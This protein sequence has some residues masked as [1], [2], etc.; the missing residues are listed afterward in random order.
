MFS[1]EKVRWA[2]NGF[3]AFKATGE[4][5]IFP[6]LLQKGLEHIVET[7]VSL[8]RASFTWNYI[9]TLWRKVNVIF[10]PKADRR[11][12]LAK[13]YRPVSLTSFLLKTMEK[14]VD[15]HIRDKIASTYPIHQAQYAY[16]KGKSTELALHHLVQGLEN[17]LR[18]KEFSLGAFLDIQGAFDNTGYDAI[19]RALNHKEVDT[20]ITRWISSMLKGRI[21]TSKIGDISKTIS[22]TRGCPQGGVLSPLLWSLVMDELITLLYDNRYRAIGYADDLAIH[23]TGIDEGTVRDDMKT[24]L[25]IVMDWCARVGLNANP[26]KTTLVPF[27]NRRFKIKLPLLVKNVN[28]P[29]KE[30]VKYLGVI[31]D[32]HLNWGPHIDHICAKAKKALFTSSSYCGKNWG[33]KPELMH[34]MYCT[35]VRPIISYAAWIWWKKTDQITFQNELKKVQRLACLKI[36][37]C[38]R[39]TPTEGI[40]AIIGLDPLHIHVK[41]VAA[42]SAARHMI[43]SGDLDLSGHSD[44]I[45][46]IPKWERL[47]RCTD[48]ITPRRDLKKTFSTTI[49][50]AEG[51]SIDKLQLGEHTQVWYTDGSKMESG[52]G[53]G[54]SGP[55]TA[56]SVSLGH[57]TTIFQAEMEA[58]RLCTDHLLLKRPKGQNFAILSDSQASIKA[59]NSTV[60]S[61]GLV[62]ECL[63]S[64][65]NLTKHNKLRLCWV[66]GHK[67][68]EGNEVADELARQ[69]AN[70]RFIGP[71]PHCGLNWS[72]V[73]GAIGE[74]KASARMAH[75]KHT[76]AIR[77]SKLL[78]QPFSRKDAILLGRND[79]RRIVGYLTGH[80]TLRYNLHKMQLSEETDCRLCHKDAETSTHIIG[81]CEALDKTRHD[82]F[83]RTNLDPKEIKM[84]STRDL[85]RLIKAAES[86]F[87]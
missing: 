42:T 6:A 28:I 64:I 7:L 81:R 14:L 62:S 46:K 59:L 51:W 13:S 74:W 50:A 9:P 4:D 80:N 35:M 33:I 52:T 5:G 24:A 85:I 15:I 30:K 8:L 37:G 20:H 56:K 60:I 41:S 69:G 82:I 65:Q 48:I 71:E 73:R 34:K 57:S 55:R 86:R 75:W 36:A 10:L 54:F 77:Q 19:I 61:T 38:M 27:T 43:C 2:I 79:L 16:Q 84:S 12:D 87:D 1:Q 70:T 26:E 21:I 32:T 53:C 58:I 22:A 68:I 29:Y 63:T 25:N 47:A 76:P 67:G 66:P 40:E 11:S 83:G 44:I 45:R 39:G 18:A 23:T 17:T 78:I 3:K 31:L 72:A 49:L